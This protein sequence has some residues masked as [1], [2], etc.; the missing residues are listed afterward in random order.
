M[1]KVGADRFCWQ[2]HPAVI[3]SFRDRRADPW[4]GLGRSKPQPYIQDIEGEAPG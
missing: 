4:G 1:L 2:S 3:K